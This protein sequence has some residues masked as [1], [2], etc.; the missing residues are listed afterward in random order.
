MPSKDSGTLLSRPLH[1]MDFIKTMKLCNSVD[2]KEFTTLTRNTIMACYD[3]HLAA[4]HTLL[5]KCIKSG[6]ISKDL[7]TVIDLS[8]PAQMMNPTIDIIGKQSQ[9]ITDIIHECKRW[10][11]IPNRREPVTK[12]MVGY[13]IDKGATKYS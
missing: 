12:D 3:A 9:L 7:S 5:Y 4:G 11:S 1:F 13:L 2:L 8:K 6:T 10:E